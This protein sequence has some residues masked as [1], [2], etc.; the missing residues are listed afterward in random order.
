MSRLDDQETE[1]AV[2]VD[3]SRP[4]D[5]EAMKARIVDGNIEAFGKGIPTEST[6]ESIGIERLGVSAGAEVFDAIAAAVAHGRTDLYY[7]DVYSNLIASGRI[8]ARAVDVARLVVDGGRRPRRS[9]RRRGLAGPLSA[10][11]GPA[12]GGNVVAAGSQTARR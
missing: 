4:L 12:V 5:A 9:S 3:S 1:L 6:S 8:H 10:R 2:A 7:E 11:V